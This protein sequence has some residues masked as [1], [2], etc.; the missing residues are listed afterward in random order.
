MVL[1]SGR[2]PKV[3]SN[4]EY[5]IPTVKRGRGFV[6]I[7]TAMCWYSAGPII[8]LNGRMEVEC[9]KHTTP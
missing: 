8:S 3:A 5:L 2:T 4:P 1:P 7:S 6:M 9:F